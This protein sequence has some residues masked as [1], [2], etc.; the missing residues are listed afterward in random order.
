MFDFRDVLDT[1]GLIARRR[2][3]Y[4]RRDAQIAMAAEVDAAIRSRYNLAIEAGTG[5]GKSF[6]YLV[7]SILYVV[8]DQARAFKWERNSTNVQ[9]TPGAS[10]EDYDDLFVIDLIQ[11]LEQDNEQDAHA[12]KEATRRV[13]V[14]TETI[15][16]Q[17]QLFQK[18]VPFLNSILPFEF[19]VA[20]AKGRSNYLC[21][22][23]F[24][25]VIRGGASATLLD[26]SLQS[27][28]Q[29]I[30]E[31]AEHT[32]DGSRSD[33]SPTPDGEIW[34]E[35]SCEQG[36]CL[37]RKCKYYNDCFYQTAHRRLDEAHVIIVNH[38]L[39]FSD[40]ALRG[41][42]GSILPNYDVLIFDEAHMIEQ[43]AG[44]HMGVEITQYSVDYLLSRLYNS[45]SN[46][47]LLVEE[48]TA[49]LWS[50]DRELF[51]EAQQLTDE[52]RYRAEN[53]FNA[54]LN[55][56]DE[57][58]GT[59][60]RIFD[61]NI[62]PNSL[63]EGLS[64]LFRALRRACDALEDPDRRQEYIAAR[65]R[66]ESMASALEDWLG[67]RAEGFVYWLEV[68][69]RRGKRRV[70]M[71]AAPIDVAV[72]LREKLFNVVPTVVATSATLA[73]NATD[74]EAQ[75]RRWNASVD[76]RTVEPSQ[77]SDAT[78]K[79]FEFFRRRVG[80]TGARA[81]TVGSPFN[82]REQMLFIMPRG[83][84]LT[85][86][87]CARRGM[88]TQ[89]RLECNER[90]FLSALSDY[91]E[92][93]DGGSFVLFTNAKQMRQTSEALQ[94]LFARKNYPFFLQSSGQSRQ[95]MLERFKCSDNGVLFGVDSFWQGVDV[96][97]QALRN[98]IIVK[99]P[100]LTP[101]TPLTEA[102]SEQILAQGGNAF[103]DYLLPTAIFKFKQGVGRL[104]RTKDDFGQ[105][106]LLDERVHRK[107]YGREFLKSLPDCRVR[108]DN[109]Q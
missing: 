90:R 87:E 77:E 74:L 64:M 44:E 53:F 30:A 32:V 54:L 92:E 29:R 100:F 60:G 68:S 55:W 107:S 5:V 86:Q 13:V 101:N 63:G 24:Q 52:C 82:Y 34:N 75:A 3:N 66:V 73:L 38:A 50:K 59:N 26:D 89:E 83:L 91:I 11:S 78:R 40:L 56:I 18:D 102:R 67:Q 35:I 98:V 96:P 47:G 12:H 37:G 62:V 97:G 94:D 27:E 2:P 70:S 51:V 46:K 108:I 6:A 4:E 10:P 42:G 71:N 104:I 80:M 9:P 43:T 7:P 72:M 76:V 69:E 14:S 61:K 41:A 106:V 28:L 21:L 58:P 103:R 31:W 45:R 1:N 20:L 57:H 79:A 16:L 15:S 33:L 109:F 93:T 84:E 19:T 88:T 48:T 105:V 22:R 25:H 99:F 65:S 85:E 81:R 23:R 39:L 95:T 49:T 8:E 17:E 36:N